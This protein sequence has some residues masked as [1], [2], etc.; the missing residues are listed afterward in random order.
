MCNFEDGD[1]DADKDCKCP[2]PCSELLFQPS[3][4]YSAL[5]DLKLQELLM[6]PSLPQMKKKFNRALEVRERVFVRNR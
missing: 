5:S 6:D 3:I 1:F 2:V 4:S